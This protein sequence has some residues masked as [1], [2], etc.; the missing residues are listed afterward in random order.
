[1][2]A[3]VKTQVGN[4]DSGIIWAI[5]ISPVGR[6]EFLIMGMSLSYFIFFPNLWLTKIQQQH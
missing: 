6:K 5:V 4:T 2:F 3:F 1:M